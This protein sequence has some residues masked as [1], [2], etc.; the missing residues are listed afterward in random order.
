MALDSAKQWV[1]RIHSDQDLGKKLLAIGD[2]DWDS[3][4]SLARENGFD[5][6]EDELAS[7][8]ES[9]YGAEVSDKDLDG[10]VGG[11]AGSASERL[12]AVA[13]GIRG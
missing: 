1:S 5:F 10:V 7:A 8:W 12:R 3:Y 6:N 2:G 13:M 11:S 9:S 4:F